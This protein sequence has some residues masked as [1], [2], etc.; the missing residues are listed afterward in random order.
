V[1]GYGVPVTESRHPSLPAE[2]RLLPVLGAAA[3]AVVAVG[4]A[5]AAHL[6]SGGS[7]PT[8]ATLTLAAVVMAVALAL[9][10]GRR[11]TSTGLVVG[12][13]GS[14]LLLH[15]WFALATPCDCA[16]HLAGQ[17]IPGMHVLPMGTL[18]QTARACAGTGEAGA[19]MLIVAVATH[20]LAALLV[21]ALLT[22][23]QALLAGALALVLPSLPTAVP[24]GL[25]ARLAAPRVVATLR[26]TLDRRRVDRRGPPVLPCPA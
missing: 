3:L 18:A 7:R 23:G 5:L 14:Q 24:V 8:V 13:G 1:N 25:A 6:V 20:A 19:T 4:L 12:L 22:R 16:G 15:Q 26:G 10:A 21:G 17:M 9:L 11:R 2:L